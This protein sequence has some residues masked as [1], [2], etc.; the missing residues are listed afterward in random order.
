VASAAQLDDARKQLL[1]ELT[2]VVKPQ[3]SEPAPFGVGLTWDADPVIVHVTPGTVTC[4]PALLNRLEIE[5]LTDYAETHGPDYRIPW[6]KIRSTNFLIEIGRSGDVRVL[7]LDESS[8]LRV[9]DSLA[10]TIV[11]RMRF[12]PAVLGHDTLV[13]RAI[14]PVWWGPHLSNQ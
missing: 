7:S 6:D 2:P 12:E 9:V 14:Q 13:Y 1:A 4:A 5:A 10:F 11:R 8:G 3:P